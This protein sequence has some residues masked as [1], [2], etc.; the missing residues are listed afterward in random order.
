MSIGSVVNHDI[1]SGV[2]AAGVPCCVIR[3]ITDTDKKKYWRNE[4]E[5]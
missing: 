5:I 1:P 3:Q 4:N 2:I